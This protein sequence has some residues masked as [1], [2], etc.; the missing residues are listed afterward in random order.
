MIRK[1][2]RPSKQKMERPLANVMEKSHDRAKNNSGVERIW[3]KL[4]ERAINRRQVFVTN[5]I[6]IICL[7]QKFLSRFVNSLT[8]FRCCV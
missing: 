8:M 1:M 5:Q 7:S 3:K 4:R 2:E 6:E